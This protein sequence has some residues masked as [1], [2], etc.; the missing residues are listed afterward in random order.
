MLVYFVLGHDPNNLLVFIVYFRSGQHHIRS[1]L[2]YQSNNIILH[3]YTI[4]CIDTTTD[5]V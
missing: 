1:F 3:K 2:L 5:N 4:Y